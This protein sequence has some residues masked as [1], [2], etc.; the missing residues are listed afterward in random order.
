MSG[1]E[2]DA[3]PVGEVVTREVTFDAADIADFARRAGD[4]NP[5]HH[6]PAYAARS[7]F[8]G[9]IASGTHYT[10][11]MMGL[12]ATHF[13][14]RRPSVGLGFEFI[15]RR[16]VP[17][18]STMRMSWEVARIEPSARL[19]GDVLHLVG[20]MQDAATGRHMLEATARILLLAEGTGITGPA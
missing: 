19:G 11:L 12:V 10:A 20:K 15:F 1:A 9:I 18:G 7:R 5:L 2:A 3:H 4:A 16:A 17:A 6:D 14:S 13:T 8:G